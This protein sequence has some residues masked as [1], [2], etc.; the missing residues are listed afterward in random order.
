MFFFKYHIFSYNNDSNT[1][2]SK[3][4]V[5]PILYCRYFFIIGEG[6]ANTFEKSIGEGIANTFLATKNR[7]FLPIIFSLLYWF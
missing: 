3:Y 5:S 7:Y 1:Q 4:R 2:G 6:I